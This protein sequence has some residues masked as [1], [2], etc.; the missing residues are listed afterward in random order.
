MTAQP[1]SA[2]TAEFVALIEKMPD[3]EKRV[4]GMLITLLGL[5]HGDVDLSDPLGCERYLHEL[6]VIMRDDVFR[7]ETQQAE[8][9]AIAEHLVNTDRRIAALEGAQHD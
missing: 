3:A 7:G 6:L 1:M 8:R 2:E 5:P 4:L 9:D